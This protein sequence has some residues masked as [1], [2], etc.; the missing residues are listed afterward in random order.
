MLCQVV[1]LKDCR[2]NRADLLMGLTARHKSGFTAPYLDLSLRKILR[3]QKLRPALLP[4]LS[5]INYN[6][7]YIKPKGLSK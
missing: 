2:V 6:G 5:L 7:Y 1:F 4:I 3:Y